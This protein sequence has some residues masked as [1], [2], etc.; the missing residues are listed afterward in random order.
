LDYRKIL[1]AY[2]DEVKSIEWSS[3]GKISL[4]KVVVNDTLITLNAS[5]DEVTALRLDEKAIRQRISEI[6]DE[7]VAVSLITEYDNYYLAKSGRLPLP[8][9]KVEVNDSDRSVYYVNP[10]NGNI[11]YFNNN[12]KIHSLSYQ[13]LHSFRFK[14]L[15]EHP[16]L[17]NIVMWTTM[18]GGTVVSFTGVWLGFKYIKRKIKYYIGRKKNIC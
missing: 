14:F 11:Q 9:Y 1:S 7:H 3:F 17:W 16:L 5:V 10:L 6:H 12:L 13:L 8:V 18:I 4:Y 2:P 15:V